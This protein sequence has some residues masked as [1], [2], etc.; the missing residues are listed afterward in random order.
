MA[1]WPA[2]DWRSKAQALGCRGKKRLMSFANDRLNEINAWV[3]EEGAARPPD[4][5]APTDELILFW[6][7]SASTKAGSTGHNYRRNRH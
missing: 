2:D 5:R 3:V 6:P 7:F 1:L 4:H